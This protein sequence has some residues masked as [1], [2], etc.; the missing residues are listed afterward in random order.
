MTKRQA[1]KNILSYEK[2]IDI[3]ER[4]TKKQW[5]KV[6]W[7]LLRPRSRNSQRMEKRYKQR[8]QYMNNPDELKG[9]D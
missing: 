1:F 4:W 7:S 5:K 6:V 3:H 9:V 8:T 2:N